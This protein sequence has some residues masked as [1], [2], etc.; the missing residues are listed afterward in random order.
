MLGGEADVARDVLVEPQLKFLLV[1]A[2]NHPDCI[3]RV[4]YKIP[5]SCEHGLGGKGAVWV[6]D[7][8]CERAIIVEEEEPS[9]CLLILGLKRFTMEKW[10]V[11]RGGRSK[12]GLSAFFLVLVLILFLS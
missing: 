1:A 10:R 8:G 5:Q 2:G 3:A 11:S 7:D 9:L 12:V 4:G 6:V